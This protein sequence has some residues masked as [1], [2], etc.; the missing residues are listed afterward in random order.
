MPGKNAT[1]TVPA[2]YDRLIKKKLFLPKVAAPCYALAGFFIF[3]AYGRQEHPIHT[4][5]VAHC[6]NNKNKTQ[7]KN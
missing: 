7:N 3:Y 1:R 5:K 6:Q 4:A 2:I